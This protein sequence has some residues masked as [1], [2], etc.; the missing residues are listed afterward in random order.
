M[1]SKTGNIILVAMIVGAIL[2]VL[3]GYFLSDTLLQIK[4]L[5]TIFLNALKMVVIPLIMASM[6]VGVTSLGDIRKLGKTTG[7]T[8]LFYFATTG[9]SVIIGLILVNIIR[10]GVGVEAFGSYVPELVAESTGKTFTDVIVSLIPENLFGAAAEGRI[11]P[12]IIFSLLFGGVLTTL[13]AK[14]KPVINFFD[15][16]NRA[17][18]KLVTLILYFAPVGVLALIGGIVAENRNS[19][20]E[21]ISGLGLYALT[22]IVGLLIHALVI[23]PLILKFMGKK[24]PFRYFVNMGQALATAFTTASSSATLPITMEAVEDKNKVD[25]KAASFVLPLGATINMDGTALYEAVAAMFIAQIYGIDLS[26]GAQVVIFLTATLA[27]IGAAGIPHAGTVTMVFVLTAVGLPLEGIG[28]IWA[29][30]WFLD[31]CRTTVNVWGDSIG[32][33]VIGETSEMQD[34]KRIRTKTVKDKPRQKTTRSDKRLTR[35]SVTGVSK[36]RETRTR[37]KKQRTTSKAPVGKRSGSPDTRRESGRDRSSRDRRQSPKRS[38][39]APSSSR[40]DARKGGD[41]KGF[42]PLNPPNPV[43]DAKVKLAQET[44]MP[45]KATMNREL[46][47]VRRHLSGMDDGEKG[48]SSKAPVENRKKDDFFDIDMSRFDFFA[49][50]KKSESGAKPAVE[51]PQANSIVKR[52]RP[53]PKPVMDKPEPKPVVDKPEPKPVMDKPELEVDQIVA[54]VPSKPPVEEASSWGRGHKGHRHVKSSDEA[55]KADISDETREADSGEPKA[56]ERQ[57]SKS[58]DA[59]PDE[60]SKDMSWGR[61][62]AKKV[63]LTKSDKSSEQDEAV[64]VATASES[65]ASEKTES[66]AGEEHSSK[67]EPSREVSDQD[68]SWG[69]GRKKT[70]GK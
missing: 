48:T 69:R 13:G 7:K 16:F 33:A 41:Q 23:L 68:D 64:P 20:D 51:K 70:P 8:L 67:A 27:S 3:G 56:V 15:G 25:S 35:K 10:P 24:D 11:L 39:H 34:R 30:D 63:R 53:R 55:P 40:D 59:T 14:G 31:R 42:K 36:S 57:D 46:E 22:V 17:I 1:D 18:M 62:R 45:S 5:G 6:I 60:G 49:D 47:K 21:L 2:G 32:A 12:L 66:S 9:F 26:I 65:D 44:A 29:I 4:F 52:S 58:G 61:H 43:P 19:V 28:L 54:D 50:E 37:D 38:H